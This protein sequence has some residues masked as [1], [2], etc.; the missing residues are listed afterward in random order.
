MIN[1]IEI[2][3]VIVINDYADNRISSF[4]HLFNIEDISCYFAHSDG[5]QWNIFHGDK[6]AFFP[7]IQKDR[8]TSAK[9]TIVHASDWNQSI[10]S[11]KKQLSHG[12]GKIFVFNGPGDPPSMNDAARIVKATIP[13]ELNPQDAAQLIDFV[14]NNDRTIPACCKENGK[15]K[16]NTL[17]AIDILCQGFRAVHGDES[18]SGF[19]ALFSRS[20]KYLEGIRQFAS[21]TRS[22]QWWLS[23]LQLENSSKLKDRLRKEGFADENAE[24]IQGLFT[25]IL[26]LLDN[27]P[28][29]YDKLNIIIEFHNKIK[30]SLK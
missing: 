15:G 6:N 17:V 23:N 14:I 19:S 13:F 1:K 3:I 25:N 24:E 9:A 27:E 22:S 26:N 2:P 21:T 4:A 28:S 16:R 29:Y 10:L 20:P 7:L 18:L 12:L 5:N 11:V 8:P 30:D